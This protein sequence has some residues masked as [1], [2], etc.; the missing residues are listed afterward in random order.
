MRAVT[1]LAPAKVNLYLG[2][3]AVRPDGYHD[4]TTV[5][6]AL[7]FGDM[8]RIL[9]ADELVVTT[10]VDLGIPEN[11]NLAYR[12]ALAFAEEFSLAPRVV[13]EIEKHMPAGAGLAGG[14]SDAAAVL[15]G[16]ARLHDIAPCGERCVSV[17]RSLGADCAFFLVGG[18]ALM[19][20]L[21]DE[22]ETA[23][24]SRGRPRRAGHAR[25]VRC[26]R[27]VRTRSSTSRPCPR[28]ARGPS[29][30]RCEAGDVAGLAAALTNN[31]T[32]ASAQ[33]VPE[34]LDALAWVGGQPGVLGAAMAGSGSATF[35]L[36]EDAASA[37]GIA[38]GGARPGLVG[39][40]HG[41]PLDRRAGH[42]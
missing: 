38:A 29:S 2:V 31:L 9:P 25:Q 42:R 10:S 8:V 7:E 4:V 32:A 20:G 26:R 35:A 28:P 37:A 1:L 13:I 18:A 17:A 12:A 40:R 15:A 3:G 33:L 39:G 21:G 5:L 22:L 16:L 27:R 19:T 30:R 41:H 11:E 14:S 34:V 6:Q 24:P 36:C 23:L